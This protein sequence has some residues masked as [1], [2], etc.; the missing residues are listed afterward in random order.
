M[1]GLTYLAGI[2]LVALLIDR[3]ALDRCLGKAMAYPGVNEL[4]KDVM[5]GTVMTVIL[6]LGTG[7]A[8]LIAN[9][10]LLDTGVAYIYP[11]F[12]IG[13]VVAFSLAGEL[14][15]SLIHPR[16]SFHRLFARTSVLCSLLC[17]ARFM[18]AP[19]TSVYP[20]ATL[21]HAAEAGAVFTGVLILFNGIRNLS[22][23][24][25]KLSMAA[26]LTREVLIAGLLLLAFSGIESLP[27]F[28]S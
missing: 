15:F 28:R 27:L 7:T 17:F 25:N 10:V 22:V 1:T 9:A 23:S 13:S 24:D 4:V 14:L 8:R 20:A 6:V 5:R 12:L 2:S 11:M 3:Y 18:D 21:T 19:A 16:A 26:R